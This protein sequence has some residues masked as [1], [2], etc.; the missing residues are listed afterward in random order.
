[1]PANGILP[2]AMPGYNSE[3][4]F[5]AYDPEAARAALAASRYGSNLPP[6][7]LSVSGYPG[8]ASDMMNAVIDQW[9]KTLNVSITIEYIDPATFSEEVR[10]SPGHIVSYGWCADYPDPEN[11]LDLLFHSQSEFNVSGYSNAEVDALLEHARTELSPE[12]RLALYQQAE[13]LLVE[14]FALVPLRHSLKH[15]LVSRRVTGYTP[16]PMGTS[17][18]FDISLT[19]IVQP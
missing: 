17:Y 12:K 15:E 5:P 16:S 18:I 4:T 19:P 1:V 14:D 2:P 7:V 6:I 13:Q 3:L 11:F 8:R 9:Q 10:K